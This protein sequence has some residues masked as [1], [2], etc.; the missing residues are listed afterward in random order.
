MKLSKKEKNYCAFKN[1]VESFLK[2]MDQLF[3]IFCK[4]TSTR[5]LEK[6][7]KVRMQQIDCQLYEDQNGPIV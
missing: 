7:Y 3:D 2:D 5:K 1:I 6:K 4:D